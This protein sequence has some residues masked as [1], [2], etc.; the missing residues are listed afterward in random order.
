METLEQ[1]GEKF[2]KN[3]LALVRTRL[4]VDE[5]SAADGRMRASV[6]A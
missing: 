3:S 1:A 2:A 6:G 5:F 4:F